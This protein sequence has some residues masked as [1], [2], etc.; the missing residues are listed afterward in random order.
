MRRDQTSSLAYSRSRRQPSAVSASLP[1]R[2]SCSATSAAPPSKPAS[3]SAPEVGGVAEGEV[4][5]AARG[6]GGAASGCACAARPRRRVGEA[7]EQEVDEE[8]AA[9]L[10]H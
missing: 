6:R 4:R 8:H 10:A 1:S 3:R 9:N 5:V 2:G 7:L